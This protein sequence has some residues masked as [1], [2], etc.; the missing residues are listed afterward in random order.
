MKK[1]A[2]DLGELANEKWQLVTNI[3][4]NLLLEMVD[5]KMGCISYII[6]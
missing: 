1:V 3:I 4:I 6:Y 5:Q 2:N